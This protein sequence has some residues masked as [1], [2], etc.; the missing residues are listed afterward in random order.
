MS[1][2]FDVVLPVR[3]SGTRLAQGEGKRNLYSGLAEA[4]SSFMPWV[5]KYPFGLRIAGLILM[6]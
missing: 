6:E 3:S 1:S 4:L 5:Y 2:S